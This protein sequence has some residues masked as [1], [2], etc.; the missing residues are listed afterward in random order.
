MSEI[1]GE[2]RFEDVTFEKDRVRIKV[3]VGIEEY[4]DRNEERSSAIYDTFTLSFKE[5]FEIAQQIATRH[6][7]HPAIQSFFKNNS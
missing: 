6:P 3:F 2:M 4:I 1:T 5:F 7:R